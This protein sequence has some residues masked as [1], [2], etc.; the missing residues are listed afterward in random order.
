LTLRTYRASLSQHGRGLSLSLTGATFKGHPSGTSPALIGHFDASTDVATFDLPKPQLGWWN[1]GED[2]SAL[3]T[4]V[5]P[6]G[7][8]IEIDGTVLA[9]SGPSGLSGTFN[10]TFSYWPSSPLGGLGGDCESDRHQFTLAR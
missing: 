1:E 10:G 8:R 2:V 5:L 7:S 3:L 4:E 6:D 9:T